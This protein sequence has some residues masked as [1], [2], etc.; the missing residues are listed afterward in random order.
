MRER[1]TILANLETVYREA[2]ER[3]RESDDAEEMA[4]LDFRFQ[5][6]QLLLEA[7]LDVRR[8]LAAR[9]PAEEEGEARSESSLLDKAEALRKITRL[10]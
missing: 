8:L 2:Y 6:D 9:P 7:V 5:R 4:R 10:R 3:A 1:E